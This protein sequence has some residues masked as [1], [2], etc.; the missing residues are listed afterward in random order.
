MPHAPAIPTRSE[1]LRAHRAGGGGIGAVLPIHYPRALLRAHGLLPVEVWGPPGRSTASGDAHLQAYTCSL[2]RCALSFALDGGL[3]D[4]HVV[5]VPHGCDSLQALGSLLLDLVP[6]GMPVVPLYLPRGRRPADEEFLA[7]ELRAVGARLAEIT[8][9][10]PSDEEFLARAAAEESADDALAALWE[11]RPN[12]PHS[13]REF[14][15]LVRAREYLPAERFEPL[16]RG[17]LAQ[18]G[19]PPEGIPMLLSGIVPEPA[20]LLDALDRLGVLVVA[21]DLACAGRR[22]YPTAVHTDPYR[23]LAQ[24]LIGGPPDP[25]RGDTLAARNTHL[26]ALAER[27]GALGALFWEVKFCEPEQFYLPS[28]QQALTGAGVRCLTVEVDLAEP[29]PA[30]AVNRIEA[31]VETLS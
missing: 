27:V 23:R 8:R 11:A 15:R 4:A 19:P 12:L 2:V 1:A 29:L 28:A 30:A 22:V 31:F 5:V 21:D 14:Y 24:S 26:K 17:A 20:S 6:P 16:A 3:R 18:P 13:N 7:A 9:R 25:M 10:H